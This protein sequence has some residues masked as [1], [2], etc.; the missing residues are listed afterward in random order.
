MLVT[1]EYG[2]SNTYNMNILRK[3]T[4]KQRHIRVEYW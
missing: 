2:Q 4:S 1:V 3:Y